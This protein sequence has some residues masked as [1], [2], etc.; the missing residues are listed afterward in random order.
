MVQLLSRS[1]LDTSFFSNW[2]KMVTQPKTVSGKCFCLRSYRSRIW[3]VALFFT[4]STLCQRGVLSEKRPC[5]ETVFRSL[6]AWCQ[7]WALTLCTPFSNMQTFIMTS[8]LTA[9]LTPYM[10][11]LC[12]KV[13]VLSTQDKHHISFTALQSYT[14]TA[15]AL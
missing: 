7:H 2:C 13:K 14:A 8:T 9:Y 6:L 12:T 15:T 5:W 4:N 10:H 11:P 1:L 3:M